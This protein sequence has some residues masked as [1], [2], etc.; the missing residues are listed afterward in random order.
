MVTSPNTSKFWVCDACGIVDEIEVEKNANG[1][2]IIQREFVYTHKKCGNRVT[3]K[4]F[5]D[6][7][8]YFG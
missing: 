5:Y 4:S 2:W 1:I 6:M 3:R 7:R 8:K